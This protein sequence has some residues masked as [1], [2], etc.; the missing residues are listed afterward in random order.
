MKNFNWKH[1]Y[2]DHVNMAVAVE[3]AAIILLG[4]LWRVTAINAAPTA[5]CSSGNSAGPGLTRVY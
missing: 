1:L 3:I 5:D 2:A 4:I